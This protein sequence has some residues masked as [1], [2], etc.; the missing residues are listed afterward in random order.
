MNLICW[1]LVGFFLG[2]PVETYPRQNHMQHPKMKVIHMHWEGSLILCFCWTFL[3]GGVFWTDLFDGLLQSDSVLLAC[4]IICSCFTRSPRTFTS[5]IHFAINANPIR[6]I[7]ILDRFLFANFPQTTRGRGDR[8]TVYG[9]RSTVYGCFRFEIAPLLR[10]VEIPGESEPEPE[11]S[12]LCRCLCTLDDDNASKSTD[13]FRW[14]SC[15]A[16]L[17]LKYFV[18]FFCFFWETDKLLGGVLLSDTATHN[19]KEKQQLQHR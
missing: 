1:L 19:P 13:F 18:G 12:L 15:R 14:S 8:S 17:A 2:I 7:R 4:Q 16:D 5:H 6:S 9:L 3:L 11:P 10:L